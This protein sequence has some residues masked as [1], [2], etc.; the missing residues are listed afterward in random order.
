MRKTLFL[1]I[2]FI[3]SVVS[4]GCQPTSHGKAPSENSQPL[5]IPQEQIPNVRQAEHLGQVLFEHDSV[6]ARAT[7][8]VIRKVHNIDARVRGWIETKQG[9]GWL[10]SFLTTDNGTTNLLYRVTFSSFLD[11]DPKVEVRE[12]PEP[13][14]ETTA[15]MFAARETA[16]NQ[17][18]QF[19]SKNY[20]TVVLPAIELG[21]EGWVVYLL[22][23]TTEPGVIVSGGH[24]RFIISPDGTTVVD[25]F[26]FTKACLTIPAPNETKD[27]GKVTGT[28]VT[29]LTSET[30]TEVHVFLSLLHHLPFYVGV[31]VPRALWE[32]NGSHIELLARKEE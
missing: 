26:Q 31:A 3:V 7:D 8:A 5:T 1:P 19:C 18:I 6:G 32:V 2:I 16:K 12:Q 10:V 24:H 25:H 9:E 27:G 4:A 29:H 23:A 20:N 28:M 30:P 21:R 15:R 17:N 14:D 13:V 11:P 22:A